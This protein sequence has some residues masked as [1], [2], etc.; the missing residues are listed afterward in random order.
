MSQGNV[1]SSS[2]V[3]AWQPARPFSDPVSR[4]C[5][6]AAAGSMPSAQW[7]PPRVSLTAT[8]RAPASWNRVAA[9]PPTF[10][11]P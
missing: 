1:R 11:N 5:R 7:I 10:P 6:W 8:I 9:I 2:L 4:L 3:T